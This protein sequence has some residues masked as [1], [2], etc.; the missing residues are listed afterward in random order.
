MRVLTALLQL[1]RQQ[2]DAA[3]QQGATAA[4]NPLYVPSPS[5]ALLDLLIDNLVRILPLALTV[6]RS[7]GYRHTVSHCISSC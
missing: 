3:A 4:D 7:A 5:A 1:E 2:H 6:M